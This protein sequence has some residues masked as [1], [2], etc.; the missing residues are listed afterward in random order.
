MNILIKMESN[1]LKIGNKVKIKI[2][3]HPTFQKDDELLIIGKSMYE[4]AWL[5]LKENISDFVFEN[6]I[7]KIY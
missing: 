1:M 4:N 6:D 5:A 3:N 2:I 7:I